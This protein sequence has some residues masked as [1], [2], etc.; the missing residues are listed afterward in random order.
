MKYLFIIFNLL[1]YCGLVVGQNNPN[2]YDLSCYCIARETPNG[3]VGYDNNLQLLKTLRNGMSRKGLDSLHINYTESQ[4]KLL[5]IFNLIRKE[6][7]YYYSNIP[8]LNEIQTNHLRIQSKQIADKITP[9]ITADIKEFVKYLDSIKCS[10]NAFS[11]LFSYVL[12]GLTWKIFEENKTIK[13][14]I[15]LDNDCP[16]TGYF[17]ILATKR[18]SKYGTNTDGDSIL[19]IAV[20]NGAPYRIMKSFYQENNLLSIMVNDIKLFGKVTDKQ[21]LNALGKFNLF[22]EHGEITIPIIEENNQSKLY[23]LSKSMS[24]KICENA[25]SNTSIDAVVKEFS[26]KD[27][28][29]A[30]VILYHEIMWDLL[31]N[32]EASNLIEKPT[33]LKEP[34]KAEFKDLADLIFITWKK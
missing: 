20:T 34:D 7:I 8:I 26:F 32:I 24:S 12:D 13:S 33:I 28:E 16:W 19:S 23:S 21:V 18:E 5:R 4:L 17:W 22:N 10:K 30:L 29:Q 9:L 6:N 1:L 2:D 3:I 31:D 11:I 27:K 25:I 15:L 14:R